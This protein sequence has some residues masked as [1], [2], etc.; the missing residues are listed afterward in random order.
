M[1]EILREAHK[2]LTKR[3]SDRINLAS[4]MNVPKKENKKEISISTWKQGNHSIK[5]Q[6]NSCHGQLKDI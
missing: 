5:M 2:G 3:N 4:Q 6:P 1:K